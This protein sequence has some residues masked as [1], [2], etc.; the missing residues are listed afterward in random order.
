MTDAMF[1]IPSRKG[2]KKI[3]IDKKYASERIEKSKLAYLK[4]A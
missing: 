3:I 4:V 2:K 1:D